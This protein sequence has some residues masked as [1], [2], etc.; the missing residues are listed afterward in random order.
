MHDLYIPL[1]AGQVIRER[2]VVEELLGRGGFGA[3]YL[4]RDL[5]VKQNLFALKEVIYLGERDRERFIF[6]SELLKRLEH[7]SLPRVYRVFE[8]EERHRAYMLMDYIDAPNLDKLRQQQPQKRFSLPQVLTIMAPIM[9]AV[10]YLHSQNPPIIHRDI[11]PA[12]II[13]PMAGDEA[14]LVDFGIAKEYEPNSTT[15]AVRYCSPGYGAPEQYSS[16]TNICTDIYGLGATIYTLLTGSVPSDALSRIARI[17]NGKDDSLEPLN[18]VT[19]ALPGSIIDAVTRA[20]AIKSGDRFASVAEFWQALNA[21]PMWRQLTAPVS[22]LPVSLPVPIAEKL[23]A[24]EIVL[25]PARVEVATPALTSSPMPLPSPSSPAPTSPPVSTPAS[26]H[27]GRRRLIVPLVFLLFLVVVLVGI[28]IFPAIIRQPQARSAVSTSQPGST[29]TVGSIP[30]SQSTPT[31]VPATTTPYAK[32]SPTS[33][34]SGF[35]PANPTTQPTSRPTVQPT[36]RPTQPPTATPLPMPNVAGNYHGSIDDTTANI[37][38]G[39]TLSIQQQAGQGSIHGSFTV[40]SPLSGNGNFTGSVTTGKSIQFTVPGNQ[41]SRPLYFW[42]SIQSD[43]S[44]N[45]NYCSLNAQ[46]Q[47]DPNAG[48]A[49]T[50]NV[51]YG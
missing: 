3:V 17:S 42:G 46:N 47:C 9:D 13:C 1:P 23:P 49:G 6:E 34:A 50:W 19:P 32:A 12:N 2:Y 36:P 45:G 39:M 4:V 31:P 44:L 18:K 29:T 8:D 10:S 27:S 22:P 40:N 28:S 15:T 38:T 11:K 20:L 35:P 14:V 43:R 21:H 33:P 7:P 26:A 5:R 51:T 41:N 48:A 24:R 25:A 30:G 37:I 16:G